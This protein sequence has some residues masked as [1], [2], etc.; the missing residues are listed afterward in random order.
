MA[1]MASNDSNVLMPLSTVAELLTAFVLFLWDLMGLDEWMVDGFF[2][3][4]TR[5]MQFTQHACQKVW[6]Q[7]RSCLE[8]IPRQ[9]SAR[10]ER[11]KTWSFLLSSHTVWSC[12]W[13]PAVPRP[14]TSAPAVSG[15]A[16]CAKRPPEKCQHDT[17]YDVLCN[18][19]QLSGASRNPKPFVHITWLHASHDTQGRL[20][21]VNPAST[22][23]KN[24][25]NT[26]QHYAVERMLH[27]TMRKISVIF[28]CKI[29]EPV[30]VEAVQP[31][32]AFFQV[33]Q[34]CLPNRR[35]FVVFYS[36]VSGL[37]NA[38]WFSLMALR[39]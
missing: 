16:R 21:H 24:R 34:V 5:K 17:S 26:K 25:N 18:L 23:G 37:T 8:A 6:K 29:I 9:T 22:A 2:F 28:V 35:F 15:P 38:V 20:L 27:Y 3:V 14:L 33:S 31:S 11:T 7:H 1:F 30:S 36:N 13:C 4:F 39:P 32:K 19:C 10:V 12:P